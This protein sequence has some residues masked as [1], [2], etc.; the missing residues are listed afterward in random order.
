MSYLV[1][2]RKYRPQTFQ[3][4]VGQQP[5]TQTL[6]HAIAAGRVAHAILF[7]GPR[8]TGKTT[9]ARILAK[10]VNCEQGPTDKPCNACKSC[11]EIAQGHST[12]VFEID[13]ASNNGVDHIRDLREN[14]RYMPAHSRYK[15]YIIDEVHMLSTPAFNALLK[16][17]EEPPAHVMFLFATTEPQKIPITILSRCQ[18]HDL[19]RIDLAAISAHLTEICRRECLEIPP[20]SLSLIARESGGSM[21][22][23]LSLLDQILACSQGGI[24]HQ[25]VI[26]ILGVIDQKMLFDLS[27]A[28]FGGNMDLILDIIAQVHAHGYNLKE[29]HESVL[30]HFRNLL[31]ARMS[32]DPSRLLDVLPEDLVFMTRQAQS[33]SLPYLSQ[34][35]DTLLSQEQSIRFSAQPRIAMEMVFIRLMQIRPT[36]PIE[37][38]I[39]RLEAYSRMAPEIPTDLFL[40]HS[41]QKIALEAASASTGATTDAA[42]AAYSVPAPP[43]RADDPHSEPETVSPLSR[44]GTEPGARTAQEKP[45]KPSVEPAT[46]APGFNPT[47]EKAVN[48]K[49][50]NPPATGIEPARNRAPSPEDWPGLKAFISERM[51]TVS[52]LLDG[53]RPGE[54]V[55]N[56]MEILPPEDDFSRSR[57]QKKTTQLSQLIS[58]YFGK[59]MVVAIGESPCAENPEKPAA[60]APQIARQEILGHPIIQDAIDIF[61]G[62]LLDVKML[63]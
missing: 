19:R 45:Q 5:V 44:F 42:P 10:S 61:K 6:C 14:V 36:L 48:Q 43:T 11:V 22:D 34:I 37:A 46:A 8:G 25:Q 49:A 62:E 20:E 41:S 7:S 59:T 55:Q 53:C 56:R 40:T 17:L 60:P 47:S 51:P 33:V 4:V 58:E 57:I 23:G 39:D 52:R 50:V 54:I 28:V 35:L 63:L 31:M 32:P 27:A 13:G 30:I 18:Q 1:L 9:I 3:E 2:A 15:I 21:R 26:Q 12:D 38:L 16:T 24:S 29:F